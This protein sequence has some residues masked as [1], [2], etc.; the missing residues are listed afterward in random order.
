[1]FSKELKIKSVN[2]IFNF[3][4]N[5]IKVVTIMF[6]LHRENLTSYLS[7]ILGQ[8]GIKNSDFINM[9]VS[10]FHEKTKNIFLD[11]FNT[12]DVESDGL[13]EY[14]LFIPSTLTVFKNN[15]YF[16][17]TQFPTVGSIYGTT[18][19]KRRIKRRRF[20]LLRNWKKTLQLALFAS[21]KLFKQPEVYRKEFLKELDL[22]SD[23]L[24]VRNSLYKK[25]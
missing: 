17:E 11:D 3:N 22:K 2:N 10:A 19:K 7:P 5:K 15:K 25:R 16:L 1:M 24:R 9:F 23:Y 18:F 6:P 8:Y 13:L 12:E 20:K 21:Y 4:K 14:E